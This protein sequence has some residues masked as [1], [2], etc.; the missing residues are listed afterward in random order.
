MTSFLIFP[1]TVL[2]GTRL[3]EAIGPTAPS[4]RLDSMPYPFQGSVSNPFVW[5][6][7]VFQ[8][9]C[10]VWT[11]SSTIK[12]GWAGVANCMLTG[13]PGYQSRRIISVTAVKPKRMAFGSIWVT[14]QFM[15]QL[16]LTSL[17]VFNTKLWIRAVHTCT[18]VFSNLTNISHQIRN[19]RHSP[20]CWRRMTEQSRLS[21][22]PFGLLPSGRKTDTTHHWCATEGK[23]KKTHS[24]FD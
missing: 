2:V 14:W 17:N 24:C 12:R 4:D 1:V 7:T 21:S 16:R 5:V 11:N 3:H 13:W 6:S 20:R 8:R 18:D 22:S 10:D 19:A 15:K 23:K 9:F